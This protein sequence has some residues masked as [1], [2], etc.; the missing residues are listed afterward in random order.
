MV[1]PLGL[2]I[3]K[4]SEPRQPVKKVQNP[5]LE[6]RQA[7]NASLTVPVIHQVSAYVQ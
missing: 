7:Y 4:Q 5:Y 2:M 6:N 3:W 1:T